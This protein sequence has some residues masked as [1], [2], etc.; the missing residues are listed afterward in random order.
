MFTSKGELCSADA[1]YHAATFHACALHQIAFLYDRQTLARPIVL[2]ACCAATRRCVLVLLG[3]V[4]PA[5]EPSA[6]DDY[7]PQAWKGLRLKGTPS[8]RCVHVLFQTYGSV[9]G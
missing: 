7:L 5:M 4:L 3:A 2:H 9:Y 1:A 6:V 8:S